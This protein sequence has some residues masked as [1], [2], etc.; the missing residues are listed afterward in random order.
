MCLAG[1]NELVQRVWSVCVLGGGGGGGGSYMVWFDTIMLK[2]K[3]EI[4]GFRCLINT[5]RKALTH[6]PMECVSTINNSPAVSRLVDTL[7]PALAIP[8]C[9]S[10]QGKLN[11]P[12]PP[13]PQGFLCN[14]C[15]PLT[16]PL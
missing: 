8:I 14:V 6:A 10:V 15:P 12:P 7:V 1:F 9:P 16:H 4:L 5:Y 13:P 11:P 2:S 3:A